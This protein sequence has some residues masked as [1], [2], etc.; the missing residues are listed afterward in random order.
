MT[1]YR[2]KLSNDPEICIF[3]FCKRK[4]PQH[5]VEDSFSITCGAGL[6]DCVESDQRKAEE[7]HVLEIMEDT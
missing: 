1:S 3:A 6:P 5:T 7:Q 2:S 4:K